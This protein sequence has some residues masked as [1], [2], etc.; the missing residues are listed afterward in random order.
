MSFS[1]E[2][3]WSRFLA[4]IWTH[5]RP[6]DHRVVQC[7]SPTVLPPWTLFS[8][9]HWLK[10]NRTYN[11]HHRYFKHPPDLLKITSNGFTSHAR[12][13]LRERK[14]WSIKDRVRSVLFSSW[15]FYA[16][17]TIILLIYTASMHFSS[18]SC[19][20]AFGVKLAALLFKVWIV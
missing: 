10:Q 19:V 1:G 7:W 13:P 9:L 12:F 3:S 11:L 8:I 16:A 14:R 18:F 4:F 20:T 17:I 5:N 15:R 6:L 2:R